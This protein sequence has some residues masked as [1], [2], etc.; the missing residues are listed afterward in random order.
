MCRDSLSSKSVPDTEMLTLNFQAGGSSSGSA[1]AVSVGLIPFALGGDGGGSIRIPA[2]FCS[3]YGLKPTHDRIS[4]A[5]SA[6]HANTCAVN[7]PLASDIRSL[8]AV[9]QVLATPHPNSDFLPVSP[10]MLHVSQPASTLEPKFLGVPEDWISW[11]TPRTQQLCYSMLERLS[12][13]YGYRLVPIKIPFLIEGQLAHAMTMLTD[14]STLLPDTH[15]I[16]YPNRILCALG[17]TTPSTD[18]LLA[19][20]LRRLL[21]QHLAHLFKQHPGMIIVTPT[22]A[23]EGWRIKNHKK[24]ERF[25]ISDGDTTLE[26]M[27]YVWMANFCGV[28][29]LV[30]PV[31]FAAA[32]GTGDENVPV[33]MMGMAE[34]GA[35]E[36][37]LQ[38]GLD[39]EALSGDDSVKRR[40]PIWI[41]IIARAKAL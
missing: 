4:H 37:L 16:T 32:E 28:P 8:A 11:A 40:P 33:G 18:Y 20:K 17:R 6:N 25:G 13:S 19:Q 5:P 36:E 1:Y 7:G 35:E 29:S 22:A 10:L 41:D 27:A 12:A 3:I 2:S 21:M 30:C 26:T 14:A 39:T 31:G 38:W 24:E 23:C 9:Y 34:W 15:N